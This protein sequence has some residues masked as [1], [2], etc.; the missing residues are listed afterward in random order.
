MISFAPPPCEDC[1]PHAVFHAVEYMD[2]LLSP[3]TKR[4]LRGYEFLASA[5]AR[6][7]KPSTMDQLY[8]Q[9]LKWLSQHGIGQFS[10][11]P[12]PH[13]CSRTRALR[14]E[15]VRRGILL[16]DFRF[17]QNESNHFFAS[18]RGERIAFEGMP[19][20]R[21]APVKNWMDEKDLMRRAFTNAGIPIAKGGVCARWKTAE[22]IFSRLEAPVI[23]KPHTGSR[24]RHTTIHIHTLEELHVAFQKAQQLSPWVIIEE[25]LSGALYRGTVIG[26]RL[27]GVLRRDPAQVTGDGISTV[28]ELVER[29]NVQPYR[30][31]GVFEP[32]PIDA[33]ASAEL[34]R[35]DLSWGS[36]PA[37][38]VRVMLNGKLGRGQGSL[39]EEVTDQTHP[40]TVLLLETAARVVDDPLIGMDFIL[41]DITRSWK[42]QTR[43]GI[44]ECNSAPFIDIHCYPFKGTPRN[45]AAALWEVVF[46]GS[47]VGSHPIHPSTNT[48]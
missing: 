26:G 2:A 13:E 16:Q 43:A 5:V 44:I 30:H 1:G 36:V 45:T 20:P 40:D 22:A 48:P 31:N 35:Q 6:V 17:N 12:H 42:G 47:G 25:E 11:Q 37:Q 15:A 14:E 29:E 19:R 3:I 32:I 18:W 41:N 8:F 38:N 33:D 9:T 34:V 24:S 46:P 28:R 7:I 10:D 21:T 23:V 39:N 27:V 4:Y